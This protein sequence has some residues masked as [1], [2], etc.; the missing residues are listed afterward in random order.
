MRRLGIAGV[1]AVQLAGCQL[2][3]DPPR[4]FDDRNDPD[5]LR[6]TEIAVDETETW[7]YLEVEVHLYDAVTDQRI[8]CTGEYQ[9]L[10]G[11]DSGGVSYQVISDFVT[12]TG[13]RLLFEDVAGL[14]LV[15]E[16]MER[17]N[18]STIAHCPDPPDADDDV[19]GISEPVDATAFAPAL[20]MQFDDVLDLVIGTSRTRL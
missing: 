16:V 3:P 17:D 13:D 19:I 10:D 8:G 2:E 12:T 11:V 15:V 7:G 18:G 5:I 1:V 6:V 14:G 20:G 4:S 9:G